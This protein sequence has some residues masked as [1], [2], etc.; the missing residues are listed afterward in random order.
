MASAN[1]RSPKLQPNE[2]VVEELT[3]DLE[4]S[5]IQADG[6]RAADCSSKK[7]ARSKG[8]LGGNAW[9]IVDEERNEDD[10][11]A[12]DADSP[13][14]EDVDEVLLKDRDLLLTESE[15][16][17]LKGEAE[18]LKQVGND[19]F[20]SGE[21]VQ[22]I[23]RYTQGLQTCPLV[24]SKERSILYAN[25]AAAKA[26]CQTEKDSAIS[27]CTKAIELNSSYVKA[28]IRRAQLYEETEKLDEA[29][30]DFKKVLTFDSSHTEANHAVRRLP[31]LIEERNE[32]LKTEM[33][34]KLKDLGNM[35]LKPF[36]LST[37]NF[38]LEKDPNSGGYSVKFHQN[39]M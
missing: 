11:N 4:G 28:Y 2:E 21:Y 6:D 38:E 22:A 32:K 5:C 30:E 37:N 17:A 34:G 25:R 23:S 18:N 20:K 24:Y 27:D 3:R 7:N 9:D 29:L 15:Q 10:D 35:V 36:G 1:D 26:K 39:P 33:L 19:L 14:S 16:E 13:P 31:P 8:T 12:Q